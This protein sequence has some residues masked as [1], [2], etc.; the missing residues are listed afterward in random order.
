MKK[1]VL[2]MFMY[3]TMALSFMYLIN[4]CNKDDFIEDDY[5][6]ELATETVGGLEIRSKSFSHGCFELVFPVNIKMPDGMIKILDNNDSLKRLLRGYCMAE[7]NRPKPELLFPVE[8]K[9]QDGTLLKIG[10]LLELK[11]LKKECFKNLLDS[12]RHKEKGDHGR[13]SLC[14]TMVY[15]IQ[16]KK[17]DG[18]VVKVASREELKALIKNEARMSHRKKNK[19]ELVF[20]VEVKL[21]D[22]NTK[23]LSSEDDLKSLIRSCED[24]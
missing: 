13:D 2:R 17:P 19:F 20:P 22:G 1:S 16:V 18:S 11:A 24:D 9:A 12:L 23:I 21:A 10:S 3:A 15:P 14:F 8:I 6:N 4:A 7:N 5:I